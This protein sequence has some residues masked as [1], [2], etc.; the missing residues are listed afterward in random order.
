[1][2]APTESEAPSFETAMKRLGEIVSALEGGELPLEES[3]R[4]FEEGVKLS[5]Q[6]QGRLDSVERRIEEL[7]AVDADGNPRVAPLP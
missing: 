2:S 4:L 3:L 7:L 5:R 1:M 6:A